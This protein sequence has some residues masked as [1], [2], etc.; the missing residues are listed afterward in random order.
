MGVFYAETDES[1]A[2]VSNFK[3]LMFFVFVEY[4]DTDFA[5]HS[6]IL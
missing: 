3:S 4:R 5:V 2:F 1:K 6:G